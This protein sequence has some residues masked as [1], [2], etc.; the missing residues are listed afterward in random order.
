M[1]SKLFRLILISTGIVALYSCVNEEYDLNKEIDQEITVLKGLSVPVG[2]LGKWTMND[3]LSPDEG[4][5]LITVS[6]TGDYVIHIDGT[7]ISEEFRLEDFIFDKENVDFE[8]MSMNFP[9][10]PVFPMNQTLVYSELTG[11]LFQAEL[12]ISID[13]ELPA[14]VDDV[15]S[16]TVDTGLSVSFHL[17][18]GATVYLKNGFEIRFP[19]GLQMEKEGYS[20]TYSITNG[21]ILVF[22]EDV[23]LEGNAGVDVNLKLKRISVPAGSVTDSHLSYN[24]KINAKGD[25]YIKTNDFASAP[26]QLTCEMDIDVKSDVVIKSAELKLSVNEDL[27][28][29]LFEVPEMPEL[30]MENDIDLDFYNPTISMQINNLTPVPF[31]IG[32]DLVLNIPTGNQ[33]SPYVTVA[34]NPFG[35]ADER[36]NLSAFDYGKYLISRRPMVANSSDVERIVVEGLGDLL[37]NIPNAET[38][39]VDY[40]NVKSDSD[41]FINFDTSENYGIFLDYEVNIPLSFGEDMKLTFTYDMEELGFDEDT[42]IESLDLRFDIHNSIPLNFLINASALDSDGR[43]NSK[44]KFELEGNIAA[45]TVASPTVNTVVVKLKSDS[46]SFEMSGLRLKLDATAPK[47][48]EGV[49]LNRNQGLEIKNISLIL[50]DGITMNLDVEEN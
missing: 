21:N 6:E 16:L 41:E 42:S 14:M 26:S 36:L 31:S 12:P 5:D 4:Q 9:L 50:P 48:Y 13:T 25:F 17:S 46:G 22:N 44:V 28:S 43:E 2:D 19:S 32:A 3:I 29:Q 38:I 27:S 49:T 18:S 34:V 1:K 35:S 8:R 45:G 39:G 10:P 15:R 24:D 37:S 40:I 7:P 20:Q 47:E 23:K 30:F 33:H 11:A